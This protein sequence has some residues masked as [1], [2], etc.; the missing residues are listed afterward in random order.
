MRTG[1]LGSYVAVAASTGAMV[2]A[3]D[4]G[5]LGFYVT[6]GTTGLTLGLYD[7]ATSASA[8]ASTQ[9]L[10]LASVQ[11]GWNFLP[12]AFVNGLYVQTSVGATLVLAN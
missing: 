9:I 7:V 10:A 1:Q 12:A 5:I 6:G 2:R 3:R 8:T 4:G 11:P